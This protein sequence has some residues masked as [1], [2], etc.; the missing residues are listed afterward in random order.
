VLVHAAGEEN[1][2]KFSLVLAGDVVKAKKPAPDI[3]LM[4]ARELQVSPAQCVVVED[5]RNGLLSA[6]AAGMKC[7]VTINDYTCEEDFP[8][9]ALVM[10]CLGD[11]EGER[12][13]VLAN[14]CH[15]PV[16]DYL[17]ISALETLLA[18]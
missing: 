17:T 9:A 14:R 16:Q 13:D 6:V 1:A 4:A 12:C 18:S 10:T 3:Y 11:P 5:S 2:R 7:V 15:A 8:E